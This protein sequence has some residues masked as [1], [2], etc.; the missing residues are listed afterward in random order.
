MTPRSPLLEDLQAWIDRAEQANL[1]AGAHK[2]LG[3]ARI[4]VFD[5]ILGGSDDEITAGRKNGGR[6]RGYAAW[7]PQ[8]K[9]QALLAQV[10][11]VLDEYEDYLPLTVRQIFYRLVGSHGYEKTER[12]YN[13]L[14][15][16]LVRARRARMLPFEA[17]RDDG[18]V[19]IISQQYDG[20]EAFHDETARRAKSYRRDRQAGQSVRLELWCEAA[21]MLQQLQRVAEPFS[22]PVYSAGGFGSLTANYEIAERA[23]ERLVPTVIL[24]VGDFD[25]SG[26]SIFIAM[27]EDAAAF[28]DADR[29][30]GTL[31]IEAVRIAL[32][33]Q[34]VEAYH[35]PTAPPKASD[36]RSKKWEGETCQLEALAPDQLAAII[37]E[38]IEDRLDLGT[39]RRIVDL[40]RADRAELLALPPGEAP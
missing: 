14:A 29:L 9:T 26:E 20:L 31:R 25:P 28:V 8:R 32:T 15:E 7:R 6:P 27:A 3:M 5:C 38:A 23:L 35:L 24:H 12:A 37:R 40:E 19:T 2:H 1:S 36:T 39:Y 11:Q 34:Q 17:I 4:N 30:I 21:G 13:R 10:E 33:A 16:A 18:V 22:V